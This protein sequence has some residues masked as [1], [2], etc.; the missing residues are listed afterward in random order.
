MLWCFNTLRH[1]PLL[2]SL[3]IHFSPLHNTVN[4]SVCM[5]RDSL[6]NLWLSA[7]VALLSLTC[8]YSSASLQSSITNLDLCSHIRLGSIPKMNTSQHM[9]IYYHNLLN[10]ST[11]ISFTAGILSQGSRTLFHC[12]ASIRY[13]FYSYLLPLSFPSFYKNYVWIMVF[14]LE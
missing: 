2:P 9:L 14:G 5:V 4:K 7:E 1:T 6:W 10:H 13:P 8:Y 3:C 12:T 11:K